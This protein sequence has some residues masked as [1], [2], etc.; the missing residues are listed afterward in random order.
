MQNQHTTTLRGFTTGQYD[1]RYA[2]HV[3]RTPIIMRT[4]SPAIL[5]STAVHLHIDAWNNRLA[6]LPPDC[7]L[8]AFAA[9]CLQ[10]IR[11]TDSYE[12]ADQLWAAV[13]TGVVHRLL[14]MPALKGLEQRLEYTDLLTKFLK[15]WLQWSEETTGELTFAAPHDFV[16]TL[17]KEL[18]RRRDAWKASLSARLVALGMDREQLTAIVWQPKNMA[19]WLDACKTEAEETHLMNGWETEGI[20]KAVTA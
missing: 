7:L 15:G 17:R 6:A 12:T 16:A 20:G 8:N 11:T 4:M 13:D 2:D 19:R 5:S 14:N 10:I 3:S 9:I 1:Y 18:I